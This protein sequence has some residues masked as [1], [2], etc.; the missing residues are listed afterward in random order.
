MWNSGLDEAQSG[1]RIDRRN[2][3]NLKYADDTTLTEESEEELKSPLMK[4]KEGSGKAGLKLNIQ[5]TKIMTYG[6]T[7]SRQMGKQWK[8]WQTLFLG[9][10]K[11]LQVVIAAMKLKDTCFLEEK[12]WPT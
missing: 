10:P 12:L 11:S 8:Q 6:P 4:V 2:I 1:I 5:K 3:N 9:A 7:T